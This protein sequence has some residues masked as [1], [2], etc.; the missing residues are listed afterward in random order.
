MSQKNL[1]DGGQKGFTVGRG[2]LAAAETLNFNINEQ[3]SGPQSRTLGSMVSG[4]GVGGGGGGSMDRSS[5]MSRHGGGGGGNHLG[6]AMKLFASL[7]LSPADL[8][9]LAQIPEDDISVETLP[10][11]LM[12]LKNRKGEA[13]DRRMAG[14][15]RDLPSL[16]SESSYQGG[17][18]NWGDM[19]GDRLG[20]SSM[21]QASARAPSQADYT[22]G[23]MQDASPARGYDLDYGSNNGGTGSRD[24]QY[25]DLSRRD[26]YGDLGMGP[27]Q[28]DNVFMQRRMGSPSQGKVQ[29]F[30]GA[31]PPMFPHVCAL[32]DFDVHSIMVSTSPCSFPAF[33]VGLPG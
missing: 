3:R 15:P 18:E 14:N 11:I 25:S 24:R 8:D 26:S 5:Q 22:Y 23:S 6:N 16:S 12:Q 10:Q 29:D 20:G 27:P 2:L 33:S 7:G 21:G 17:R 30:L 28:S 1:S 9:A 4:M 32:C 31:M 19:R 13:G